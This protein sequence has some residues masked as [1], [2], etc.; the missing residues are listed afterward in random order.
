LSTNAE[1]APIYYIR[2]SQSWFQ[3]KNGTISKRNKIFTWLAY[4]LNALKK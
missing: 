2:H 4:G 3:S 1:I